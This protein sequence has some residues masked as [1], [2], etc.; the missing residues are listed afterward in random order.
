[1]QEVTITPIPKPEKKPRTREELRNNKCKLCYGKKTIRMYV[2]SRHPILKNIVETKDSKG[3]VTKKKVYD[4]P[5]K[6]LPC[7]Y[8]SLPLVPTNDIVL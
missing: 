6:D 3:K 8:C 4:I 5:P 2:S 1:M 7:Y